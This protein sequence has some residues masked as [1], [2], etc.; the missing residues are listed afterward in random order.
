MDPLSIAAAVFTFCQAL[1]EI[2]R[3]KKR[4]RD[5]PPSL[6][7]LEQNC[8]SVLTVIRHAKA[9]LKELRRLHS[10]SVVR[11]IDIRSDLN[12]YVGTLK[13]DFDTVAEWINK[14]LKPAA[15]NLGRVVNWAQRLYN[16]SDL[17][18]MHKNIDRKMSCF[19]MFQNALIK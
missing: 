17:E 5:I 15:H 13:P 12:D 2:R 7:A 6:V 16:M 10:D 11:G 19:I 8:K 14:R 4:L 1:S 9:V 3:F 18:D